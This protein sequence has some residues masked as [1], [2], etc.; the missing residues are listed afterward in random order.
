MEIEGRGELLQ[1]GTKLLPSQDHPKK[2]RGKFRYSFEF[3]QNGGF[4]FGGGKFGWASAVV[5]DFIC[6]LEPTPRLAA[7]LAGTFRVRGGLDCQ[8]SNQKLSIGIDNCY[9]LLGCHY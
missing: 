1:Q 6:H 5:F 4:V 9:H 7:W 8:V 3:V 2:G